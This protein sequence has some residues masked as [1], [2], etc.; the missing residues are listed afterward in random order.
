[1]A[2]VVGDIHPSC[3]SLKVAM[4]L[5]LVVVARKRARCR[6]K[7]LEVAGPLC[8]GCIGQLKFSQMVG[9]DIGDDAVAGGT[10]L[11]NTKGVSSVVA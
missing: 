8:C 2:A 10:G 7:W 3:A 9:A 11:K 5:E 4:T 6:W 1:M